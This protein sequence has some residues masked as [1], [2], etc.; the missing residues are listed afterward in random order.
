MRRAEVSTPKECDKRQI[1]ET[2]QQPSGE[3]F[4]Q[5]AIGNRRKRYG[6]T[7]QEET[8]GPYNFL[9]RMADPSGLPD[10]GADATTYL[11]F[12]LSVL[13]LRSAIHAVIHTSST[14]IHDLAIAFRLPL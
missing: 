7:K 14:P 8:G 3:R 4:L 1:L 2:S 9:N 10:N 11:L 12:H 5:I 13:D 6:I